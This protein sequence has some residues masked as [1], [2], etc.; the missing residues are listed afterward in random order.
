MPDWLP[1]IGTELGLSYGMS[2]TRGVLR[3]REEDVQLDTFVSKLLKTHANAAR[4]VGLHTIG[5]SLDK[6]SD[7]SRASNER[8]LD[9][10]FALG[11]NDAAYLRANVLPLH[12]AR[13]DT[14][15][16]ISG[17]LAPLLELTG[18]KGLYASLESHINVKR[19]EIFKELESSFEICTWLLSVDEVGAYFDAQ[20][21]HL[22]KIRDDLPGKMK[23]L[24]DA[25]RQQKSTETVNSLVRGNSKAAGA[26]VEVLISLFGSPRKAAQAQFERSLET[27]EAVSQSQIRLAVAARNSAK[28]FRADK[29]LLNPSRTAELKAA[30]QRS[31]HKHAL[32][33]PSPFAAGSLNHLAHL[34]SETA[35]FGPAL[36]ASAG[37]L[38]TLYGA[39]RD[40]SAPVPVRPDQAQLRLVPRPN[41]PG[42]VPAFD[43]P[44]GLLPAPP[45]VESPQASESTLPQASEQAYEVVVG[46]FKDLYDQMGAEDYVASQALGT[47]DYV[48]GLYGADEPP[49]LQELSLPQEDAERLEAEML[50]A[51]GTIDVDKLED[52]TKK[53]FT[54]QNTINQYLRE[55]D[56]KDDI[57]K[58]A[59]A[60]GRA[61]GLQADFTLAKQVVRETDKQRV[62]DA[63]KNLPPNK[64]Q[65]E[66]ALAEVTRQLAGFGITEARVEFAV[67][68]ELRTNPSTDWLERVDDYGDEE[69]DPF[70]G[71]ELD[72]PG[73]GE[74]AWYPPEADEV[75]Q[76]W[77]NSLGSESEGKK[78]DDSSPKGEQPDDQS[79]DDGG[80]P[81]RKPKQS[82]LSWVLQILKA[83]FYF[84]IDLTQEG[85]S[86]EWAALKLWDLLEV[87]GLGTYFPELTRANVTTFVTQWADFVYEKAQTM[88]NNEHFRAY[89]S[90]LL[91]SFLARRA[92]N[93][94][95]RPKAATVDYK[96]FGRS[97]LSKTTRL[98][99]RSKGEPSSSGSGAGGAPSAP[100]GAERAE[101][102]AR[103]RA[104]ARAALVRRPVGKNDRRILCGSREL[105]RRAANGQRAL[106][107]IFADAGRRDGDCA[108]VFSQQRRQPDVDHA[109]PPKHKSPRHRVVETKHLARRQPRR[110]DHPR[111]QTQ[112]FPEQGCEGWQL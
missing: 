12:T 77:F 102:R 106:C 36:R 55:V 80:F 68:T 43:Q 54:M 88:I 61:L 2:S 93:Y 101:R 72:D 97:R 76:G 111:N 99:Q 65:Y 91:L 35:V 26:L 70:D 37:I 7:P 23:P 105:R 79:V 13:G 103:W 39:T 19:S 95:R 9:A 47:F 81:S 67:N 33:K 59:I 66:D 24:R 87:L 75:T 62:G 6:Q 63:L 53:A 84:K 41:G 57:D 5:K 18:R 58:V 31:L 17:E 100:G 4:A 40:P 16:Q 83:P 92:T 11:G 25:I 86:V 38:I 20:L 1:L 112:D 109:P 56:D 8:V 34:A 21:E 60:Y 49:P 108:W 10:R 104:P 69:P 89:A 45:G 48:A 28:A 107:C 46:E 3:G 82:T 44:V 14:E 78:G 15:A 32:V 98:R 71:E 110:A 64:F 30:L 73:D 90:Q 27:A 52:R 29:V 94:L 85:Y 51:F 42:Y 96:P 74:V 22:L 50:K